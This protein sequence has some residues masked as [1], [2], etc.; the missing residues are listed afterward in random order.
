MKADVR[1][2]ERVAVLCLAEPQPAD[3][4]AVA[5]SHDLRRAFLHGIRDAAH[6][7][8]TQYHSKGKKGMDWL[9]RARHCCPC[10]SCIKQFLIIGNRMF[11]DVFGDIEARVGIVI[12]IGC[13]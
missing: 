7:L 5:A 6:A 11:N 10:L 9:S 2:G 4:E 1:G 8:R 13:D 3:S 12:S